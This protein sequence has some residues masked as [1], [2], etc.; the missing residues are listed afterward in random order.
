MDNIISCEP[1]PKDAERH[2]DVNLILSLSWEGGGPRY[3]YEYKHIDKIVLKWWP[4]ELLRL[5]KFLSV[6][7]ISSFIS[8]CPFVALSKAKCA[9]NVHIVLSC[10]Y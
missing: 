1:V 2:W 8:V 10:P 9:E 3:K 5:L 4:W 7:H 6:Y